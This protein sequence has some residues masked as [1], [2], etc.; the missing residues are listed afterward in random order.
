[1]NDAVCEIDINAIAPGTVAAEDIAGADGTVLLVAGTVLTAAMLEEIRRHGI[2]RL[3]VVG[4]DFGST[5]CGEARLRYLFRNTAGNAPAEE[6][7]R[8]IAA[9]RQGE[10]P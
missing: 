2:V 9:Y 3:R 4:E 7:Q 5:P 10:R 6:L 8:F 1:M